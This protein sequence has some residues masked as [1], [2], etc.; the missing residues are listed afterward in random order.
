L[1]EKPGLKKTKPNQMTVLTFP[2]MVSWVFTRMWWAPE[3]AGGDP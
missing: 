1:P 2:E 3:L